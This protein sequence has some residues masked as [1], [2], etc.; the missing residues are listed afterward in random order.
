ME[1]NRKIQSVVLGM[2]FPYFSISFNA[3][4]RSAGQQFM[5]S[6]E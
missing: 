4:E 1:N 2:D 6:Y 3:C 5:D